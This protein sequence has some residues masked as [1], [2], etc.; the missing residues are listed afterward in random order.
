MKIQGC[1]EREDIFGVPFREVRTKTTVELLP[2]SPLSAAL[3]KFKLL[4]GVNI[5]I[6]R[7]V[8]IAR[9]HSKSMESNNYL[10][11]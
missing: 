4:R 5:I 1:Y 3:T 8:Q 2:L 6:K 9:A 11:C 10:A 7:H